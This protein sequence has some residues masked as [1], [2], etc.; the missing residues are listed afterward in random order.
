MR[1]VPLIPTLP[2]L[3]PLFPVYFF[4][5]CFLFK[6]SILP[7]NQYATLAAALLF[8]P[9]G[10]SVSWEGSWAAHRARVWMEPAL[11]V[12]VLPKDDVNRLESLSLPDR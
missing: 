1:V 5:I 4:F 10:S 6:S 3:L 9:L 2:I 7:V 12:S 8:A 11:L